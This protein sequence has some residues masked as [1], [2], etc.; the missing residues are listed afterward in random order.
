MN[1]GLLGFRRKYAKSY[2]CF[3]GKKIPQE[4][5]ERIGKV[6]FRSG[7]DQQNKRIEHLSCISKTRFIS[8]QVSV[9]DGS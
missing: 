5:R 3:L 4:G 8:D 9:R 2:V 6:T 7:H 1:D